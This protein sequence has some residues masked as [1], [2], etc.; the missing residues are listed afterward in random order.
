MQI[1]IYMEKQFGKIFKKTLMQ[2]WRKLLDIYI[3]LNVV[4]NVRFSRRPFVNRYF[5]NKF[6]TLQISLS[7]K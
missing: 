1:Y 6:I 4:L 3:L 7:G 2:K 5:H